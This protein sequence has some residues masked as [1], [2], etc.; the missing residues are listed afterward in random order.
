MYFS[1][2]QVEKILF[3]YVLWK[4]TKIFKHF[5]MLGSQWYQGCQAFLRVFNMLHIFTLF[6]QFIDVLDPWK[7]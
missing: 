3:I 1:L 7:Q 2:Q 5:L 6:K 4:L